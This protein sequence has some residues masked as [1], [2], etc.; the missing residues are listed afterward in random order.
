[1]KIDK[2]Y[3]DYLKDGV[4]FLDTFV[5]AVGDVVQTNL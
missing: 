5:Y 1:M 2:I 3:Y 4:E